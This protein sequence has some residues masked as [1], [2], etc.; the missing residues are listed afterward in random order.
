MLLFLQLTF[1]ENAFWL[2]MVNQCRDIGGNPKNGF[3]CE[4]RGHVVDIL[5]SSEKS[6]TYYLN[7]P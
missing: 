3:E 7:G 5:K 4:I 1:L 6:F 2:K